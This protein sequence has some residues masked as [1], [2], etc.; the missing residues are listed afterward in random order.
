[1]NVIIRTIPHAE[2]PYNTLGEYFL[3]EPDLTV[4]RKERTLHIQVSEMGSWRMEMLVAIHELTE[5]LLMI[6]D[7]IPLGESNKFDEE[8]EAAREAAEAKQAST[9][10]FRGA[11]YPIEYE[12][13]DALGCPY[14]EHHTYATAV[15]RLVAA[16]LGVPWRAYEERS[17]EVCA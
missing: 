11:S 15:E 8:F 12:P 2:Q 10:S 7:G 1:M 5:T 6:A 14:G 3:E 13:G 17:L 9:F 16:R 4:G